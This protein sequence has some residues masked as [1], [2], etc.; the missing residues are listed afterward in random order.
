MI[1][2]KKRNIYLAV[3]SIKLGSGVPLLKKKNTSFLSISITTKPNGSYNTRNP[4]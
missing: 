3:R 2:K 4:K 1:G